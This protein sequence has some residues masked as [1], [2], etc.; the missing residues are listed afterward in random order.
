MKTLHPIIVHFMLVL[1]FLFSNALLA[2]GSRYSA[3]EQDLGFTI[4]DFKPRGFLEGA[5]V[6]TVLDGL[7]ADGVLKPEDVI[8]K[9]DDMP[10][11][12]ASGAIA[13]MDAV[14]GKK[15][16]L[17]LTIYRNG[18]EVIVP[19]KLPTFVTSAQEHSSSAPS[20]ELIPRWRLPASSS[21]EPEYSPS[22]PSR[23]VLGIAIRDYFQDG[24]LQGVL[25]TNVIRGGP[26]EGV[27]IPD[28]IIKRIDGNFVSSTQELIK[29]LQ[30]VPRHY[31]SVS[32][33]II[34][35]EERKQIFPRLATSVPANQE[36]VPNQCLIRVAKDRN[37]NLLYVAPTSYLVRIKETD[38]SPHVMQDHLVR[39]A[40]K[41]NDE[42]PFRTLAPRKWCE[43]ESPDIVIPVKLILHRDWTGITEGLEAVLGR[44]SQGFEQDVTYVVHNNAGI[45]GKIVSCLVQEQSQGDSRVKNRGWLKELALSPG[46]TRGRGDLTPDRFLTVEEYEMLEISDRAYREALARK[47][48]NRLSA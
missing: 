9:I 36:V 2:Q 30:Q 40:M 1:A 43:S 39:D 13:Y 25:V 15:N 37:G 41:M 16:D 3:V 12:M 22:H 29:F 18:V 14:L 45:R 32:L 10:I 38:P 35:N 24:E 33:D 46:G 47:A 5:I 11:R 42:G 44:A 4:G 27:L 21:M 20:R 17:S 19:W 23:M 6:V 48:L 26:A 8:V 31:T 7:P 34:R 28:D